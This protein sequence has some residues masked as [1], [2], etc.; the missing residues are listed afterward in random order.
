MVVDE[1]LEEGVEPIDVDADEDED[2]DDDDEDEDDDSEDDDDDDDDDDDI[3]ALDGPN[4]SETKLGDAV[5]KEPT[6]ATDTNGEPKPE[7]EAKDD[8]K[9]KKKKRKRSPSEDL[10]PP[11]PP[12]PTI[13]LDMELPE[14]GMLDWNFLQEAAKAGYELH[15]SNGVPYVLTED[16]NG[17]ENGETTAEGAAEGSGAENGDGAAPDPFTPGGIG[18]EAAEAEAMAAALEAKW[19]NYGKTGRKKRPTKSGRRAPRELYDLNDDF[20]DD[21]DVYIDMPTHVARPKKEGF[22]VHQGPLELL[23]EEGAGPRRP[24]PVRRAVKT[25]REARPSLSAALRAKFRPKQQGESDVIVISDDEGPPP[26]RYRPR[27]PSPP[28]GDPTNGEIDR[29]LFK[30]APRE[31]KYLPP[32]DSFPEEVAHELRMLRYASTMHRWDPNNK[33]KFPEHL[34]AYL[35]RAGEAAFHYD[36]FCI[37]DKEP[38]DTRYEAFKEK[39]FVQALCGMLPYNKLTLG[40]LVLKLCYNEYWKWL[41]AC[42]E[43]GLAQWREILEPHIDE[44]LEEWERQKREHM[45][46][47]GQQELVEDAAGEKKNELKKMPYFAQDQDLKDIFRQLVENTQ[48][49]VEINKKMEEWGQ[50]IQGQSSELNMRKIL[51][52]KIIR[53]YPDDFMTSL[54]L[55]RQFTNYKRSGQG[56]AAA[57]AMRKGEDTPIAVD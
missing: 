5:K 19:A 8:D 25:P 13:R 54:H 47:Q 1:Q 49:M 44:M 24:K 48:E 23:E 29:S 7:G 21:S 53:I 22:F 9:P 38:T 39:A 6:D 50:P 20:I 57:A 31:E 40:K 55:S 35:Q 30:N 32:Y 15:D 37:V 27:S 52:N 3:I 45:E 33:G 11:P 28:G 41:Q 36:V 4:G 56:A 17:Q 12:M 2:D 10:A 42:E 16:M 18:S 43:E 14:E 51:Y 26:M 46:R 34:K